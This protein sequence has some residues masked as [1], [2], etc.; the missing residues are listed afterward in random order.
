MKGTSDSKTRTKPRPK[1]KP[2]AGILTVV[3][4]FIAADLVYFIRLSNQAFFDSPRDDH[5]ADHHSPYN[6]F[7]KGTHLTKL[8]HRL[9]AMR[10]TEDKGNAKNTPKVGGKEDATTNDNVNKKKPTADQLELIKI[11]KERGLMNIDDKGP[12]L[13]ILTQAGLDLT[14]EGDLDQETI[15]KLPTWTHV[16]NLYGAKPVILGLERC[17]DFRNSV[18]ATTRFLGMAGTFNTGTNL[19]H[20]V[21]KHNCQITERMEVYGYKSKGVRWQVPWGKHYMARY[22]GSEHSTHTDADVPH[23]HTMALV[24]IRDPYSWMQ[25]MC[26]HQYAAKWP[27]KKLHCPN[28]IAT[29]SDIESMPALKKKYGRKSKTVEQLIPVDIKYSTEVVHSHSSLAHWYSEWYGDYLHADFP[30]LIVRFE[31]LLFHG[32]EVARAMCECG[33]GVPVPDNGRSG[34]FVHVS[35]SAKTGKSAHGPLKDRTNL[36]GALIKYGSFEHR[37]DLMTPEDLD[38]ARRYLD[39]EIMEAF[40]YHHPASAKEELEGM[41]DIE[42]VKAATDSGRYDDDHSRKPGN[43]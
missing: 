8:G 32:E 34:K 43:N 19:I 13:E 11:A 14:K 16:N 39:P 20:A 7:L 28:L 23:N 3:V 38:A 5:A 36:V 24:S 4:L 26:R 18:P 41:K 27:N 30:R 25:S 40:G 12:I 35:E 33:G 29:E 1:P 2:H 15:D 17:E 31:D 6:L 9:A 22:R 21:M 37:T 42:I 10:K